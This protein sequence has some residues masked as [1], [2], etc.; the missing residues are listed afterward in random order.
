MF[1]ELDVVT[2]HQAQPGAGLA[3]GAIGTVLE[4]LR[5]GVF[6]VEFANARGETI[7]MLT[8]PGAQLAAV[9][10]KTATPH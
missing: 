9:P 8:L 10:S 7:D 5:G 1:K 3:A 2:L 6:V 4:V